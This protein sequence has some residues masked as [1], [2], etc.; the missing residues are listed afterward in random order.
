MKNFPEISNFDKNNFFLN[1]ENFDKLNKNWQLEIPF[2]FF[3]NNPLKNFTKNETINKLAK[4]F[5]IR[6]ILE[7]NLSLKKEKIKDKNFI[8]NLHLFLSQNIS[9]IKNI[10]NFL[11]KEQEIILIINNNFAIIKIDNIENSTNNEILETQNETLT[12]F[13]DTLKILKLKKEDEIQKLKK[14]LEIFTEIYDYITYIINKFYLILDDKLDNFKN[15][16]DIEEY[17]FILKSINFPKLANFLLKYEN[18]LKEDPMY[19]IYYEEDLK[20]LKVNLNNFSLKWVIFSSLEESMEYME[21]LLELLETK[22]KKLT[23]LIDDYEENKSNKHEKNNY[24]IFDKKYNFNKKNFLEENKNQIF[25]II[26]N[27][28]RHKKQNIK[29]LL[30]NIFK[31]EK[32]LKDFGDLIFYRLEDLFDFISIN[33]SE[34]ILLKDI[35]DFLVSYYNSPENK[36]FEDFEIEKWFSL[37]KA[38]FIKIKTDFFTSIEKL[39][40]INY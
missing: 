22:I 35:F 21:S 32:K 7:K 3:Q 5:Q 36:T 14:D 33:C 8:A 29:K 28:K 26:D 11:E 31:E 13:E 4:K 27:L 25:E 17:N 2:N 1:K 15:N 39:K 12:Y 38:D 9:Q 18:K 6:I 16:K 30:D 10:N 40:K 37:K 20:N 23:N 19:E 34:N 24:I